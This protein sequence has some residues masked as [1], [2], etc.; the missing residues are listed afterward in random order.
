MH[1]KKYILFLPLFIFLSCSKS[2]DNLITYTFDI[3]DLALVKEKI[4]NGSS[5]FSEPLKKLR[6]EADR[7][8][9]SGPWTIVHKRLTPPSGDKHDYI[10]NAKYWWPDP[11]NPDGPY[12]RR[13]GETNPHTRTVDKDYMGKMSKAVET[14]G[15]ANYFFENEHYADHALKIL[16]RWFLD[17]ST[18]MNPNMKY[19]QAI[20]NKV[21]GRSYGIIET[22]KF[23]RV[24]DA[25]QLLRQAGAISDE[26]YSGLQNWFRE[27]LNWL[28]TSPNGQKESTNGNNHE[29]ACVYQIASFSLFVGDTATAHYYLDEHFKSRIINMIEP[30]GGQPRELARTKS[31][32]YSSMNLGLMISLCQL[33]DYFDL[34]LWNYKTAD[35]R[36][37]KTAFDFLYPSWLDSSKWQYK[38]IEVSDP[39]YDDLFHILRLMSNH[40]GKV[41]YESALEKI[42]GER[43]GGHRGQLYWTKQS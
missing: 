33:G 31:L 22:R 1:F 4:K 7:A 25:V 32:H 2:T 40:F 35:G 42:Y 24:L 28:L 39:D 11:D 9:E 23:I 20:P 18:K 10:S 43:Y 12:I 8:L 27:Y 30:S 41:E 36:S 34:D 26:D 21:K 37:I 6:S 15:L 38:Q 16:R 29:T 14:L 17:D 13:D 19:A 5:E 3:N